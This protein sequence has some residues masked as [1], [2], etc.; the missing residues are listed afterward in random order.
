MLR[1]SL[2]RG[3]AAGAVVDAVRSAVTDGVRCRDLGG[4]AS[5][6]EMTRAVLERLAAG[7]REAVGV[8]S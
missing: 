2:G 7:E 1:Q 5:T 3:V 8:R 6:D 4:E